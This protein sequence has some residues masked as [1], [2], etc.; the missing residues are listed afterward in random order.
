MHQQLERFRR[1]GRTLIS[2]PKSKWLAS[3]V[4]VVGV[5]LLSA[6]VYAQTTSGVAASSWVAAT[7]ISVS[8]VVGLWLCAVMLSGLA[9]KLRWMSPHRHSQLA[10]GV[11]V[12]FGGML[13]LAM[14][15]PYLAM[16]HPVAAAGVV[17]VVLFMALVL[18]SRARQPAVGQTSSESN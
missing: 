15:M 2:A 1:S 12:L 16:N 9:R 8:T 5:V 18:G 7:I 10:R 17:A 11:Q 13:L 14:M 3:L 6:P 4:A